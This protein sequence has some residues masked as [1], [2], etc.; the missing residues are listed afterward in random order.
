MQR[1]SNAIAELE[2][3]AGMPGAFDGDRKV[4]TAIQRL[5]LETAIAESL[6]EHRTA[7][8]AAHRTIGAP[9]DWGY[10]TPEGEAVRGLYD[11]LNQSLRE[12]A[13]AA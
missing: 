12:A 8:R 9:G 3:V 1:V 13:A 6:D 5:I 11:A 10:G 2:R 4:M 7:I